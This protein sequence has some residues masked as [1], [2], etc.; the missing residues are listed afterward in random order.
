[1]RFYR[2]FTLQSLQTCED[3]RHQ[4]Q[5]TR[6]KASHMT[7]SSVGATSSYPKPLQPNTNKR[8]TTCCL[9]KSGSSV[10]SDSRR[11]TSDLS[12]KLLRSPSDN[13][14]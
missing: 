11:S 7:S 5:T 9:H 12:T 2:L 6:I 10:K 13:E 8:S 4:M 1:M 14:S 3:N